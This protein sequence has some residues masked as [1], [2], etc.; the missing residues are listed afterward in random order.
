MSPMETIGKLSPA[1]GDPAASEGKLEASLFKPEWVRTE[2]PA[3]VSAA[4]TTWLIFMDALGLGRQISAQLSGADQRVFEVAPGKSF[5]RIKKTE[6]Q[7]NPENPGDFDLLIADIARWGQTPQKIVYLWTLAGADSAASREEIFQRGF[8]GLCSVLRSLDEQGI[9]GVDLAVVSAGLHSVAGE[10]LGDPVA[11]ALLGPVRVLPRQSREIICRSIDCDLAAKGESYL[12][13]QIISEHKSPFL[14]PVVAYRGDDRWIQTAS[15][16]E[17][18]PASG[19]AILKNGGA[20]LL[21]QGLSRRSLALAEYLARHFRARVALVASEAFPPSEKWL[22]IAQHTA[23]GEPTRAAAAKLLEIQSHQTDL[24]TLTADPSRPEEMGRAFQI[25]R[26]KFGAIDGVFC[27]PPVKS[28]ETAPAAI[29][30]AGIIKEIFS[31]TFALQSAVGSAPLDFFALCSSDNPFLPRAG[32]VVSSATGAFFDSFAASHPDLRGVSIH[33]DASRD[34]AT[35]LEPPLAAHEA[36]ICARILSVNRPSPVIASAADLEALTSSSRQKSRSAPA[37]SSSDIDGVLLGWWQD[38]LGID[39]VNLDDDFFELGGHSLIGVQL[40]SKIKKTY[41]V[42]LGLSTLFEARTVRQLAQLIRDS[43]QP[44]AAPSPRSWSPLV[45]IQPKGTKAPIFVISGLGG[46]VVKFQALAF[47]LGEDQPMYGLI[48]RGLD[49][50]EPFHSRLEDVAADYVRA[51]REKQPD[52]PC[53]LVGY[54]FGGIVAFEVAQ[55]LLAQGSQV[56]MLAFFDTVEWHYGDRVDESLGAGEKMQAA[57][58]HL[59]AILFGKDRIAYL[60]KHIDA[61][62]SKLKQR[63]LTAFG[64]PLPPD[65]TSIEEVNSYI[66]VN[67]HPQKYSGKITL[68]RSMKRTAVEGDDPFLGWGGYAGG[69]VQVLPI[70]STHFNILKEPNVKLVADQLRACVAGDSAS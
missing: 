21:T 51:I 6:Y 24:L 58:E 18:P 35:S 3:A 59:D 1:A 7:I 12:A 5:R 2:P 33:V 52:G 48:P 54:S 15:R 14:D 39:P 8:A 23:A 34:A 9:P 28:D 38:L 45:P 44:A 47:H 26:E 42:E 40:F 46:N 37:P 32:E 57:K 13:V 10:K 25:A 63:V 27:F 4:P 36:E 53:H 56:G 68:F 11:A 64:R 61:R 55:Q 60:K 67:Y 66:A 65:V 31:E 29:P 30:P 16:V 49:G 41:G 19:S 43:R 70:P 62:T 69:G 20:Y 17:L 50:K 22:D